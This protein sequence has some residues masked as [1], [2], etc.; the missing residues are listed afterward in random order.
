MEKQSVTSFWTSLWF[1][2]R[3][4]FLAW[5]VLL[6]AVVLGLMH[7]NVDQRNELETI[8]SDNQILEATNT[9]LLRQ[10]QKQSQL[11]K[12]D[13]VGIYTIALPNNLS[14]RMFPKGNVMTT[15]DKLYTASLLQSWDFLSNRNWSHTLSDGTTFSDRRDMLRLDSAGEILYKWPCDLYNAAMMWDDSPP[16]K[17]VLRDNGYSYMVLTMTPYTDEASGQR[18]CFISAE[19]SK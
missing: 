6:V 14:A 9:Y 8:R 2:E 13:S 12:L 4:S 1:Y 19:Y 16:H 17:K 5:V 7:I 11:N 15:L 3:F 10:T 18:Q